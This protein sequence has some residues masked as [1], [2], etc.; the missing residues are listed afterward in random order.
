VRWCDTRG[1]LVL[2]GDNGPFRL[3]LP[4]VVPLDPALAAQLDRYSEAVTVYTY[5]DGTPSC[6]RYGVEQAGE[7]RTYVSDLEK[8]RAVFTS[9]EVEFSPG[10]PEG[11]RQ[12]HP[13]PL[14][15]GDELDLVGY[16]WL[17]GHL[18]PGGQADLLTY[19][20]VRGPLTGQRKVFVHLLDAHSQIQGS[21]DGL[22][23]G[24]DTLQP[25]DIIVQ[26]H[27]FWLAADTQPGEHQVE[28]GLYDPATAQR[29]SILIDGVPV[30]D[31]LLL[32]PVAVE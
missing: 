27:R 19:W 25:G 24:L 17:T 2:P 8:S 15:L 6:T 31:R 1:A 10:D 18:T 28:I 32:Q 16:E 30:A 5:E 11:L 9:P 13:L 3:L 22:D 21:H 23:A 4:D 20:C 29:R 26:L 7:W 12:P 14:N